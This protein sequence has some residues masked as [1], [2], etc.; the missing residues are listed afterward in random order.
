LTEVAPA[1]KEEVLAQFPDGS[2]ALALSP[3]GRG[4]AVFANFPVAPDGSN[5]AGSPLFPAMLHE[6]VRA[7]RTSVSEGLNTPGNP[8]QIDVLELK[9]SDS[10]EKPYVVK[11]PDGRAL[12]AVV[13]A[14]GR[15][16]RLAL[17]AVALPGHYPV[18]HGAAQADVGV[19]NVDPKETDTRPL[20][21]A[22]LVKTE[23]ADRGATIS[24]VDDEGQLTSAGRPTELWPHLAAVVAV[25]LSGEML[26]LALWRRRRAKAVSQRLEG[27]AR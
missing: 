22:E 18:T 8:W 10:D 12:D 16:V 21:I 19:V 20:A 15:T 1:R 17:P 7:L 13:L 11:A 3:A 23:G 24:V 9:A 6:L 27:R 25:C 14:R 26:L 4:T 5:I 2:A